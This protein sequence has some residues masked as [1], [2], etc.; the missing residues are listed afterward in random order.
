MCG[1]VTASF[2]RCTIVSTSVSPSM[3]SDWQSSLPSSR[4]SVF[5]SSVQKLVAARARRSAPSLAQ[6]FLKSN[7]RP[8][9]E[10]LSC[11]QKVVQYLSESV[12]GKIIC[13]QPRFVSF[14]PGYIL[15]FFLGT[16]FPV[17]GRLL[18]ELVP[19]AALPPPHSQTE[20][21][22]KCKP[23]RRRKI[24]EILLGA[25]TNLGLGRVT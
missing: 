25:T 11:F 17:V 14:S 1:V 19:T 15:C 13:T 8:K 2:A 4:T 6:H 24:G 9:F 10:T 5:W 3:P 21:P 20:W 23:S 22:R 16:F 7:T 18:P 12:E